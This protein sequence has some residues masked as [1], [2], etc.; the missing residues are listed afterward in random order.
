MTAILLSAGKASRLGGLAPDG[1]KALV[2]VAG[3]TMLDH[4]AGVFDDDLLVVVRSEHVPA[5]TGRGIDFVTCDSGGGPAVALRTGLALA[6]E[7]QPVTVIYA[8]TWVP[9]WAVPVG[10]DWCAVA[11]AGGGRRWDTL[12]EGQLA[13]EWVDTDEVALVAVGLYRFSDP[14]RLAKCL[15]AA[16]DDTDETGLA[17]VVNLYGSPMVPVVGWQD[18]GDPEA[19]DRWGAL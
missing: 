17:P 9:A 14:D 19:I 7:D 16:I 15:A 12:V 5:M 13:Y 10:D 4:W 18:V 2:K 8:D 11:A 3:T 1:C 6:V